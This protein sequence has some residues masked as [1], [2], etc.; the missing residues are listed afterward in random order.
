MQNV[1][2]ED[3]LLG[4]DSFTGQETLPMAPP[5]H[6]EPLHTSRGHSPTSLTSDSSS[7]REDLRGTVANLGDKVESMA[8]ALTS[9]QNLL[10]QLVNSNAETLSRLAC[11]ECIHG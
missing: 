3:S 6:S 8:Q 9:M 2:G 7:R 1:F 10:V 5:V 11:C 4:N